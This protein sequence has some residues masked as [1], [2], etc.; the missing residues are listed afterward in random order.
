MPK[1]FTFHFPKCWGLFGWFF[2][3]KNAFTVVRQ[4]QLIYNSKV[5]SKTKEQVSFQRE[6]VMDSVL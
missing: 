6:K 5:N 1:Y 3:Q 4:I 2:S